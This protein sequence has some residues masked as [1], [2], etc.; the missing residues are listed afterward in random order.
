M[1]TWGLSPHSPCWRQRNPSLQSAT[2]I[3]Q[4]MWCCASSVFLDQA[5]NVDPKKQTRTSCGTTFLSCE[6]WPWAKSKMIENSDLLHEFFLWKM[7][8]QIKVD[9]EKLIQ[10]CAQLQMHARFNSRNHV[11]IH[12]FLCLLSVPH[13]VNI[14]P[15]Y[16]LIFFLPEEKN[17]LL[18]CF[19]SYMNWG[20]WVK[21]GFST[22]K[23]EF[24]ILW[25]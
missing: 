22:I 9:F 6:H 8:L 24:L 7:F 4:K 15:L 14:L 20:H 25:L 23:N 18:S 3:W 17:W 1:S 21:N 2:R 12:I 13:F 19:V 10:Q 5:L 11:I 16:T